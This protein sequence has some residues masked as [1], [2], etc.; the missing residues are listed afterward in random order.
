[1]N[2][3][4]PASSSA[5]GELA[6]C[7]PLPG[8]VLIGSMKTA[9]YVFC[10]S[11]AML[12]PLSLSSIVRAADKASKG[13]YIAYIGTYTNKQRKGIYAFR[14]D[15]ATGKLTPLGL[16]GEAAS[17]SFLAI[18]PNRKFLYA[19]IEV[20]EFK[21]QKA[22]AVGAFSIDLKTSK[23][24]FLNQVSSRGTGPCHVSVDHT[25]KDVLVANYD[26]ASVP[27]MPVNPPASSHDASAFVQHTGASVNKERQEAPHAHCIFTSPDNRFALAADLGLEELLVYRFDP[28]A[29]SFAPNNPPPPQPPPGSGPRP[30]AFHPNRRFVYAINEIKCTLSTFSWDAAHGALQELQTVS[31]LPDGD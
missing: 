19:A 13:E 3:P 12:L 5:T 21:G 28:A 27:V 16:A 9:I 26:A 20:N 15:A 6:S 24:K 11:A 14:F 2:G 8:W 17:P 22:G 29:G 1:M 4:A 31:T 30:F 23:L 25:G 18:H 7:V 10:I